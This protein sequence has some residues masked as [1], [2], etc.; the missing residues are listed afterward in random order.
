VRFFR[1]FA[2]P[3]F[4]FDLPIPLYWF[5]LHPFGHFWRTRIRA[6]FWIAGLGAWTCG[7]AFLIIF[8]GRWLAPGP[9]LV[10]PTIAGVVF[11]VADLLLFSRAAKDMGYMSLVGHAELTQS[12]EL[13]LG[14]IYKHVRHPR[15]AGMILS[16]LGGC[17]LAGTLWSWML[18]AIWLPCVLACIFLEE[19]ELR[20]RF[21]PAY[22]E[23][24]KA[25]PRFFPRIRNS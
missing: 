25:V 11:V 12:M 17:L 1:Y 4:F 23:Y 19:R 15:Y 6:A 14:G 21:G 20:H 16:M 22:D 24:S 18:A 7:L 3:I 13:K 5:I 10:L 8:R 9:P 2:L